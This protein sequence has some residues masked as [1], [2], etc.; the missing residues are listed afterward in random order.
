MAEKGRAHIIVSGLVQGVF[1]RVT[2]RQKAVSLGLRGWV[3]N[4]ANGQVEAVFEGEK[5]KVQEMVE[6]TR[7]GFDSAQVDDIKVE[8]EEYT[9]KFSD[10]EVRY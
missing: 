2:T 4:L 10:F 1:F 6:W 3:K 8:W 7:K 5:E 9:G